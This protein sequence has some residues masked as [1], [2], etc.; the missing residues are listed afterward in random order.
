MEDRKLITHIEDIQ[1]DID[2]KIYENKMFPKNSILD[3]EIN[4]KNFGYFKFCLDENV[5]AIMFEGLCQIFENDDTDY[6]REYEKDVLGDFF[7]VLNEYDK[8]HF[9]ERKW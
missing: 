6:Q 8:K 3:F 2:L 9:E 4:E 1:N 7:K 5:A